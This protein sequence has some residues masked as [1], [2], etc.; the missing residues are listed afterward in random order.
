[1][2]RAATSNVEAR[3]LFLLPG[4]LEHRAGIEPA[5]TGFA[6]LRVSRFATGARKA[7]VRDQSSVF[8]LIETGLGDAAF[9]PLS[10]IT[11]S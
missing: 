11:D 1:M 8:S 10:L 6:D 9:G 4:I 2:R 5:Y 7:V 3:P